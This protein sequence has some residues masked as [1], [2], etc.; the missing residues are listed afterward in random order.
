MNKEDTKKILEIL[1]KVKEDLKSVKKEDNQNNLNSLDLDKKEL[2]D[3]ADQIKEDIQNQ[4]D[5]KE[6]D[7]ND[8]KKH[9]ERINKFKKE[10]SDKNEKNSEVQEINI[11]KLELEIVALID[12]IQKLEE[13]KL[14]A[15]AD[16]QNTVRR[17]QEETS[18][19]KKYGGEKLASEILPAIDMFKSVV[20]ST[21]DNPEIKNYLMGFQM[22]INQIDQA[23]SNAGI[24][25]IQTKIGDELNP[26]LHNA[27]EQVEDSHLKSGKIAEVVS[28]G[29]RL[30][31]RVI[32][33]VAVKVAK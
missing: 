18:R 3:M 30:H 8:D 25:M 15:I 14:M 1:D 10:N 7:S 2:A 28:N 20:A 22:I 9:S 21:P 29:Y 31:D 12:K 32:K 11:D 17:F 4:K 23:L 27:I 24:S 13:S 33:H 26:E 5:N 19:V 16:N 6:N